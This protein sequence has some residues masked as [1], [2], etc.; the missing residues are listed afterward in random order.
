MAIV[1][2]NKAKKI[3]YFHA[4]CSEFLFTYLQNKANA[5]GKHLKLC[6]DR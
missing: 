6:T 3:F 1:D 2:A 5:P 4:I